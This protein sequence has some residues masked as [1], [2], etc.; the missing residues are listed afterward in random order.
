MVNKFS[1]D[2]VFCNVDPQH[3]FIKYDIVDN[4]GEIIATAYDEKSANIICEALN[5]NY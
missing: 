5:K 1:I 3:D 2:K 4:N